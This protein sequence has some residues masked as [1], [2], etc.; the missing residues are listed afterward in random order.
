FEAIKKG[1]SAV[2]IGKADELNE[3]AGGV[4]G[5]KMNP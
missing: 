4:F 3:L 5:T 1:V 2:Y